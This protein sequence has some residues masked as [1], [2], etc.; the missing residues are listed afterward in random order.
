M[1]I[2]ELGSATSFVTGSADLT[3]AAKSS[4]ADQVVQI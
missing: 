1:S 3:S 4:I 2:E